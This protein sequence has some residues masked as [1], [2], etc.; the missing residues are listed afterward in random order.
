[1][2]EIVFGQIT[3]IMATFGKLPSKP[4]VAELLVNEEGLKTWLEKQ[5]D[6]PPL[7]GARAWADD[8][9][10]RHPLH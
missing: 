3:E 6:R 9:R 8:Y 5:K 7:E 10:K 4:Q 1:M 2:D